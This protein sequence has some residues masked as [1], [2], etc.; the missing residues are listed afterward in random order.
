MK[1]K[2]IIIVVLLILLLGGVGCFLLYQYTELFGKKLIPL[3]IQSI[4]IQ[5]TPGYDISTGEALNTDEKQVI[6]IQEIK[7][8]GSEFDSIQKAIKKVKKSSTK[9]EEL[10]PVQYKIILNDSIT[11]KIG[12]GVGD[13]QKGKT[14]TPITIP[15]STIEAIDEVVSKN[16]EKVL[17]TIST[18]TV[19]VKLEGA[20][21]TIKNT[22]NLKYINDYLVY[23]PIQMTDDYK[24]YEDGYKIEMI[25]DHDTKVYLYNHQ[26]GYISQKDGETDIST[27]GVFTNDLYDLIYQIYETSIKE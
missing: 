21:I 24:K 6:E 20:S 17:K 9:N 11:L 19:T 16:N 2:V 7:L 25:L 23:Y 26:I 22:D 13:I 4:T 10:Y 15:K 18:E 14:Y 3:K 27:Y 12:D 8:K 1:K 5:Y